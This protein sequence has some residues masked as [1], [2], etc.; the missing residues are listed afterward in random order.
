MSNIVCP[1]PKSPDTDA[2]LVSS[3]NISTNP[4][5]SCQLYNHIC[6]PTRP[7]FPKK[8]FSVVKTHQRSLSMFGHVCMAIITY[9]GGEVGLTTRHRLHISGPQARRTSRVEPGVVSGEERLGN[10]RY[11][12]LHVVVHLQSIACRRL[13]WCVGSFV[14]AYLTNRWSLI[15]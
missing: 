12:W 13:G 6:F 9:S 11:C 8:T 1:T 2:Q 4:D 14:Y 10:D 3:S 7:I 5:R 15:G